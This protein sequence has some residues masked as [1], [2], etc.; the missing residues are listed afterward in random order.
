MKKYY[1]S[2]FIALL[3]LFAAYA[4]Y[5]FWHMSGTTSRVPSAKTPSKTPPKNLAAKEMIPK[6]SSTI[7]QNT[8]I[9]SSPDTHPDE[10]KGD[11]VEVGEKI[12]TPPLTPQKQQAH[13]E[14][15]YST[16]TP[17]EHEET[18]EAASDAFEELDTQVDIVDDRLTQE[19]EEAE[20]RRVEAQEEMASE[21]DGV[22]EDVMREPEAEEIPSLSE[23]DEGTDVTKEDV[24]NP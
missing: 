15:I 6:S 24:N 18:M 16:L 2:V 5:A 19:M 11:P 23:N 21:E 3:G 12:D 13:T 17:E 9:P 7:D 1:F 10:K 20:T 8:K 14:S 4:F 22:G